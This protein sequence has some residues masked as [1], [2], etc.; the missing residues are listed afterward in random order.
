[1]SE[2]ETVVKKPRKSSKDYPRCVFVLDKHKKPLMP[3]SSPRARKLLESGRAV[4]HC[5]YPFVIRLKDR[6]LKDSELQPI[7]LGI[8]P[9]SKETGIGLYRIV[10]QSNS[11]LSLN[12]HQVRYVLWMATIVHRPMISK[13]LKTRANY[14]KVRRQKLRY[15]PPRFNNRARPKG[16]L[17][18]SIQSKLDNI[19]N[20]VKKIIKYVP[21]TLIN[22]EAVKFDT[23]SKLAKE[24]DK[25]KESIITESLVDISA[26]SV[27]KTLISRYG[28]HCVYCGKKNCHLEIDHIVPR[29]KGG[30]DRLSNLTLACRECNQSKD[31][32][33]L[34]TFLV[35][36]V[37]KTKILSTIR[38]FYEM[39]TKDASQVQAY[40]TKLVETLET[41]GPEVHSGFGQQTKLTRLANHLPKDHCVDAVC[42]KDYTDPKLDIK[43]VM[44]TT[45]YLVI[46]AMG[47]GKYQRATF[48]AKGNK[49]GHRKRQKFAFGYQTGDIVKGYTTKGPN[50]GWHVGRITIDHD[51]QFDIKV[52]DQKKFGVSNRNI[53]LVQRSDGYQY[54]FKDI[55]EAA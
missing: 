10:H 39:P 53:K 14:R 48:D 7:G 5:L 42:V 43:V 6:L 17:P 35:G 34:K 2:V 16:W 24:L 21:V 51:G 26:K 54:Y 36:N 28:K 4:V 44:K 47:R 3:C 29:S 19:V 41:L 46:K 32:K 55:G 30:T 40:K 11:Q 9:G 37:N 1:M 20:L 8:D 13:R 25:A 31:N 27:M 15:R 50:K 22:V 33:S 12:Y 49:T 38:S 52:K 18:P 23:R 45:K